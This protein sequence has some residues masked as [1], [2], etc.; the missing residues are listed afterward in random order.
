MRLTPAMLH[1]PKY[2]KLNAKLPNTSLRSTRLRLPKKVVMAEPLDRDC[3]V[4]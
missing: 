3:G 1:L 4:A 2:S